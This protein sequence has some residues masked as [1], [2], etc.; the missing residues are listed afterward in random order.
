MKET[1]EMQN[2][3]LILMMLK[4]GCKIHKN[5]FRALKYVSGDIWKD[6]WYRSFG[7]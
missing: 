3:G 1:I 5:N 4:L 6:H 7:K 2:L